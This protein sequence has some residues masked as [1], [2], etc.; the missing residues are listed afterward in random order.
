MWVSCRTHAHGCP[1]F[2][3]SA[4]AGAAAAGGARAAT[5][6]GGGDEAADIAAAIGASLDLQEAN[7]G[8]GKGKGKGKGGADNN[9]T[10]NTA[11][12]GPSGFTGTNESQDLAFLT[13]APLLPPARPPAFAP[14]EGLGAGA[15]AGA[16][17]GGGGSGGAV[18]GGG[19]LHAGNRGH[20]IWDPP[21]GEEGANRRGR[22]G[23][24][25]FGPPR[26][27]WNGGAMFGE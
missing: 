19:L 12:R 24:P 23:A 1:S 17:V 22:A 20:G 4:A 2:A 6:S 27:G 14:I 25:G 13:D 21:P 15:G 16:G 8:G 11:D 9:Y 10:N 5:F 7:E 3:A 26:I 18:S